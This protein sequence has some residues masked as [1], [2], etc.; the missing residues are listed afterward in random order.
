MPSRSCITI[1]EAGQSTGPRCG[2]CC[3]TSIVELGM[4]RRQRRDFSGGPFRIS[5][6]RC[7]PTSRSCPSLGDENTMQRYVIEVMAVSRFKWIPEGV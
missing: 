5:L 3:I 4:A 6:K 2:R 1:S 7:Y